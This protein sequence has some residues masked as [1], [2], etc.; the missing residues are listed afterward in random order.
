M[1]IV[2]DNEVF[3]LPETEKIN[4]LVNNENLL[5]VLECFEQFFVKK[6]NSYCQI[7][8]DNGNR[9][10]TREISF[11]NVPIASI[12]DNLDLKKKSSLNNE[13]VEIINANQEKFQSVESIRQNL[14]DFLS[15]VGAI[16][17]MRIVNYGIKEK[18]NLEVEELNLQD[19]VQ[20]LKIDCEE[21]SIQSKM[22]GV[23]N[24]LLYVERERPR[25]VYIDFPVNSDVIKWMNSYHDDE[26]MFIINSN[27]AE[28]LEK[29]TNC[30]LISLSNVD[31]FE[32]FDFQS[33]ELNDYLYL[34][35]PFVLRNI[36]RQT[37]EIIHKIEQFSL[38]KVTYYLKFN[39]DSIQLNL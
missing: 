8:D 14:R 12:D 23:Y 21:L 10:K 34:F 15:D 36:K 27:R 39:N 3:I 4:I 6:K 35:N 5:K 31:F 19:I 1:K 20:M 38:E 32:E 2:K 17:I 9:I 24:L 26:V 16:D 29:N 13:I 22:I 37:N 28:N 18:L 25:L 11:V 7:Y 33:I 30:A